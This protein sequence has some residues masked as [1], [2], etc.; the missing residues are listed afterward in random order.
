[1]FRW[2]NLNILWFFSVLEVKFDVFEETRLVSFDGEVIMGLTFF[3][4]VLSDLSLG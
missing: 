2:G 4:Q 3:N 1:M